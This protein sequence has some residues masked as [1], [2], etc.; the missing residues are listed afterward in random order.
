M[1]N[2]G[3]KLIKSNPTKKNNK[4]KKSTLTLKTYLPN[5]IFMNNFNLVH[6]ITRP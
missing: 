1:K 2:D 5:F 3:I 4:L 6:I